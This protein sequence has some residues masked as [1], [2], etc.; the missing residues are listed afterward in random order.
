MKLIHY[1]TIAASTATVL[2][3]II[4]A[5]AVWVLHRARQH[6]KREQEIAAKRQVWDNRDT[7][8]VIEGSYQHWVDGTKPSGKH[9]TN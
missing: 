9:L 2:A 8:T 6:L 4:L 5:I 1:L 3:F 7:L